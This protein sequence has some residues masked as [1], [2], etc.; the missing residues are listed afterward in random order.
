MSASGRTGRKHIKKMP[1]MPYVP[2]MPKMGPNLTLDAELLF[3]KDIGS[4][5][6]EKNPLRSLR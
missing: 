6:S 2:K 5:L 3:I 1:K 4:I